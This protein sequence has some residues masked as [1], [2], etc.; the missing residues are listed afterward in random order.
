MNHCSDGKPCSACC[1][2][3]SRVQSINGTEAG[4]IKLFLK[5][6]IK[7]E[8]EPLARTRNYPTDPAP[9]RT[10]AACI[11]KSKFW[12]EIWQGR[13][14]LIKLARNSICQV[15]DFPSGTFSEESLKVGLMWFPICF[16]R[17]IFSEYRGLSS[18]VSTQFLWKCP[19]SFERF[20][21]HFGAKAASHGD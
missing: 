3:L 17:R 21:F 19:T 9:S 11:Q 2:L 4:G 1:A 18:R 7:P 12:L 8:P 13:H 6:Q 5:N 10:R 20:R 15:C 14:F 16:F